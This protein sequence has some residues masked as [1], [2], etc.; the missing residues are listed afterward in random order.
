MAKEKAEP[1]VCV[2]AGLRGLR[3]SAKRSSSSASESLLG[4]D[5]GTESAEEALNSTGGS[6]TANAFSDAMLFPA[7]CCRCCARIDSG[8]SCDAI[9]RCG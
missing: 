5:E 6:V 9:L 4:N 7:C 3:G 2:P 1:P 8:G